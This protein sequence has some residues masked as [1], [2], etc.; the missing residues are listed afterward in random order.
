MWLRE[1]YGN[2]GIKK[3]KSHFEEKKVLKL[4]SFFKRFG[5]FFFWLSSFEIQLIGSSGWPKNY[6]IP[7][8]STSLFILQPDLAKSSCLITTFGPIGNLKNK[9]Q[10]FGD[11]PQ[12]GISQI[13]LEKFNNPVIFWQRVRTNCLIMAN[14]VFFTPQ[15]LA[16]LG[17]FF[18]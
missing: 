6:R 15:N 11:H 13:W 18:P 5:K 14:S 17:P 4:S 12:R 7:K 10:W 1:L 8:C 9:L 3:K 2:F 16:T